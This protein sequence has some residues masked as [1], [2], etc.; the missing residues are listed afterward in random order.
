MAMTFTRAIDY[1]VSNMNDQAKITEYCR[2]LGKR[3]VRLMKRGF[4]PSYW[5]SFGEAFTE[6]AIDWEGEYTEVLFS[7]NL[8]CLIF[9]LIVCIN[10]GMP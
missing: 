6:C 8:Y 5:N 2:S 4:R 1:I 7:S 9:Y 3:H 10:F